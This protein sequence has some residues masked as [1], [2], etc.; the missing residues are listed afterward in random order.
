MVKKAKVYSAEFK[1]RV[2]IESIKGEL[3]QS[4]IT[5][6][7][8]VHATQIS[9]WKKQA[10]ENIKSG[11]QGKLQGNMKDNEALVDDLYKEIGRQK[12]E[13][14]WLKKRV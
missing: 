11:F 1:L 10:L 14:E 5:S 6:R 2:V 12:V 9:F 4:Q 8:G 3:T 7:Y 13:L